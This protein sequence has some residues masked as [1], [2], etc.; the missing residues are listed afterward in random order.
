VLLCA[1]TLH[2]ASGPGPGS[3][4]TETPVL[5]AMPKHNSYNSSNSPHLAASL[6]CDES[7]HSHVA[8]II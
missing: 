8:F 7:A 4:K 6:K 5:V 3:V 1:Y 2:T